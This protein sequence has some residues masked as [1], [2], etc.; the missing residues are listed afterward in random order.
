MFVKEDLKDFL[1]AVAKNEFIFPAGAEPFPVALKM[2]QSIGSPDSE[3]RDDLIYTAFYHWI[4]KY[5]VFTT[6]QLHQLLASA[7]DENHL[8]Y[9]I[10]HENDDSVFTRSFSVLLLPLLLIRHREDPYL[11][12]A[13]IQ[14]I[15][16]SLINYLAAEQDLRGYTG[17]KGWAHAIAHT[18]DALDDLAQC[19][20]M[21]AIDLEELLGAIG[22]KMAVEK[23]AYHFDEDERMTTAVVSILKR[24]LIDE[25]TLENWVKNLTT[26]ERETKRSPLS[27]RQHNVIAFLRCL[28]FRIDTKE[29][30]KQLLG[31]L[32]DSLND[33]NRYKE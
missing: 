13:E 27:F 12:D 8:F 7:L 31:I 3:L 4:L 29:E 14:L 32:S 17:E 33:L 18:G 28:Y 15:K 22:N 19:E 6:G 5:N 9:S 2:M 16:Q 11:S 10:G 24:Q 25:N 26:L 20:E 30:Y 23:C 21:S 1:Q